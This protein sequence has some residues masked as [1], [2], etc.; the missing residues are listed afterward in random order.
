[1][2]HAVHAVLLSLAVVLLGLG[3]LINH[4]VATKVLV[5]AGTVLGGVVFVYDLFQL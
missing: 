2:T 5:V 4:P 1:M 3:L